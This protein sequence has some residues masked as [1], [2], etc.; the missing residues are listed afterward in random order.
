MTGEEQEQHA[1][2]RREIRVSR[3]PGRAIAACSAM[4]IGV[5]RGARAAGA[6]AAGARGRA[7]RGRRAHAG[8]GGAHADRAGRAVR[9]RGLGAASARRIAARGQMTLV[10][11]RAGDGRAPRAEAAGARIPDRARVRVVAR[12][13]VGLDG[14][15]ARPGERV[16]DA[17]LVA[18]VG[19]RAHQGRAAHA[20]AGLASIALGAGVVVAA[21]RP[22]GEVR[23]DAGAG[24]GVAE[25][26][27]R[28]AGRAQGEPDDAH[29]RVAIGGGAVA[30]TTR[31]ASVSS[32]RPQLL[33][34]RLVMTHP[35]HGSG[36]LG[37][38]PN[39]GRIS[40]GVL[41]TRS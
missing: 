21:P 33:R 37:C 22:V 30:F 26:H 36:L 10:G 31:T 2:A 19:R 16:A 24:V 4:E 41:A 9:L 20:G 27:R 15:R 6:C 5:V 23:D 13:A 8:A 14:A 25:G 34:S 39:L 40:S 3:A 7:A 29:R 18:R 35:S 38:P 32:S 1:Q 11:R 17:W 12:A 28:G